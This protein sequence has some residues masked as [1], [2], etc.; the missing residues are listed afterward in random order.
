MTAKKVSVVRALSQALGASGTEAPL[1]AAVGLLD[2]LPHSLPEMQA[3]EA[4]AL[5]SQLEEAGAFV[6]IEGLD[7][8]GGAARL[9]LRLVSRSASG[10]RVVYL[11]GRAVG[12]LSSTFRELEVAVGSGTHEIELRKPGPLPLGGGSRLSVAVAGDA[13]Q[14]VDLLV[15]PPVLFGGWTISV[16]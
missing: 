16:G 15:T 10:E 3:D 9:R 4:Q 12:V 14:T 5:K 6:R 8:P 2:R 11:G 7:E 13:P 1:G